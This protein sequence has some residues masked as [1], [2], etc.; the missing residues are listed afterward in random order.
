[1]SPSATLARN[2]TP[3]WPY[4]IDR[5]IRQLDMRRAG[6]QSCIGLLAA[7][8]RQLGHPA[9]ALERGIHSST[10]E[11]HSSDPSERAL[12]HIR[13]QDQAALE[14]DGK[15]L[16]PY[17]DPSWATTLR[18]V[19]K[20]ILTRPGLDAYDVESAYLGEGRERQ[21]SYFPEDVSRVA[22]W[23]RH[24]PTANYQPRSAPSEDHPDAA[25]VALG[26]QALSSA[27]QRWRAGDLATATMLAL[28]AQG[29]PA[30]ATREVREET[31]K[32][33]IRLHHDF[34]IEYG[35]PALKIQLNDINTAGTLFLFTPSA[36]G[37]IGGGV[38]SAEL[39]CNVQIRRRLGPLLEHCEPLVA[40]LVER[41][42]QQLIPGP[43]APGP[44][45]RI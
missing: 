3:D 27:G 15:I 9:R 4:D 30:R 39:P 2:K 36:R 13:E 22:N 28:L 31:V 23:L 17:L 26:H 10:Y 37:R 14:L 34:F 24:Y 6:H 35:E 32:G 21:D 38:A 16:S 7:A 45:A 5:V 12:A 44:K 43:G 1:M 11:A 29:I 41:H 40:A 25:I 20:K 42:L 19:H 33:E 8:L 18:R